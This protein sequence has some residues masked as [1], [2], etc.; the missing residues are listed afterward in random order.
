MDV[1]TFLF[2][3]DG[4]WNRPKY[5]ILYYNTFFCRY[6][7]VLAIFFGINRKKRALD[8]KKTGYPCGV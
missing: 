4:V 1:S 3:M 8:S 7:G 2:E 6:Q 5:F